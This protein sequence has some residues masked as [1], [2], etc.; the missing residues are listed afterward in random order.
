MANIII[1]KSCWAGSAQIP[2]FNKPIKCN[3]NLSFV[4][5]ETYL[6]GGW[7]SAT[8]LF[9]AE[10]L[11]IHDNSTATLNF[12]FDVSSAPNIKSMK[13]Q[14]AVDTIKEEST[15]FRDAIEDAICNEVASWSKESKAHLVEQIKQQP[16][17]LDD[18]LWLAIQG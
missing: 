13:L 18:R 1:P 2:L 12:M 8:D 3:M 5:P 11:S 15:G 6:F 14:D 16:D 4:E 7:V 9:N 17:I 10:G